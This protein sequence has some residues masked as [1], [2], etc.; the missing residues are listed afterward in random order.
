VYQIVDHLVD[1]AEMTVNLANF[2]A[3]VWDFYKTT[4]NVIQYV[5]C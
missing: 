3:G 2:S 1:G 5:Y 4:H